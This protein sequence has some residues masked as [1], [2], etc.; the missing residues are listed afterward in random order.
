MNIFFNPWQV[1]GQDVEEGLRVGGRTPNSAVAFCTKPRLAPWFSS[2]AFKTS[3]APGILA[4][5]LQL[6]SFLVPE[7][8]KI[9]YE[10]LLCSGGKKEEG[11]R[12]VHT[13]TCSHSAIEYTTGIHLQRHIGRMPPHS[14]YTTCY[15]ALCYQVL[16]CVYLRDKVKYKKGLINIPFLK[17]SFHIHPF[18][19]PSLL[20]SMP[21]PIWWLSSHPLSQSCL[22]ISLT[23]Q[24]LD[25]R[26]SWRRR[27]VCK[28]AHGCWRRTQINPQQLAC[29]SPDYCVN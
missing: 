15:P 14:S 21:W 22:G 1:D 18:E 3:T 28:G 23:V 13:F 12:G 4:I 9:R 19:A 24:R 7:Y 6:L 20:A 2:A 16:V 29:T 25:S 26:E 5:A 10:L 11:W 27:K 8:M 17:H